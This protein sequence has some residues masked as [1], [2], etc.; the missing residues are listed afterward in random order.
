MCFELKTKRFWRTQ[1]PHWEVEAGYYFI[2][3]RCANSLPRA[4]TERIKEVQESLATIEPSDEACL[5]L[6]RRYFQTIEKY[7]DTH[8][9]FCPFRTDRCARVVMQSFEELSTVGWHIQHYA[10]MPN[11]VH[12]LL[13]T[14]LGSADMQPVLTRWKGATSHAANHPLQRSGAFWQRDWF[15]RVIRSEAELERIKNYI[16]QNPVK[17]GL[18]QNWQAY[19]YVR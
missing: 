12:L 7:A 1:L 8:Q 19:S 18:C 3:I 5:L 16:Q 6:Q 11:H 17:A 4:V 15:D 9:G 14:E 13:Q 10:I 2:T